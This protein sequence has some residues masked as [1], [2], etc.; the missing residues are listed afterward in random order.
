MRRRQG[1]G[2]LEERKQRDGSIRYMPRLPDKRRTPLGTFPDR[3]YAEKILDAAVY[4]LACGNLKTSNTLDAYAGTVFDQRELEGNKSVGT[5]RERWR[6]VTGHPKLGRKRWGCADWPLEA[7]KKKDVVEWRDALAKLGLSRSTRKN[8]LSTLRLV[9]AAAV[10]AG[11]LEYNPAADVHVKGKSAAKMRPLTLD[12]LS[13]L[14]WNADDEGKHLVAIAVGTCIRQGEHR[15]LLTSEVHVAARAPYIEINRSGPSTETTKSER[16]RHVPLFGFALEAMRTWKPTPNERGLH[17]ATSPAS[18]SG[19]SPERAAKYIGTP[20][21]K[22]SMVPRKRWRTWLD[23]AGI[24]RKVRWHDLRHTGATLL[25]TGALGRAW[26]LEE[27]KDLL[28]HSSLAVTER[29][30]QSLNVIAM[31]AAK[32]H[33]GNDGSSGSGGDNA[34]AERRSADHDASSTAM[35]G[36]VEMVDVVARRAPIAQRIRDTSESNRPREAREL[37][38]ERSHSNATRHAV[39]HDRAELEPPSRLE[40]ETY[41]LRTRRSNERISTTSLTSATEIRKM[42]GFVVVLDEA[43]RV[44]IAILERARDHKDVP[45]RF[46]KLAGAMLD[47]VDDVRTLALIAKAGAS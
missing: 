16:S 1:T 38:V 15:A 17:F 10:D 4:E 18:L 43:E 12:Q 44:A 33:G 35:V 41:G 46:V 5:E 45:R 24:D 25:L 31:R 23:A 6:Y 47:A 32:E 14:F 11:K 26:S 8:A 39:I 21:R 22:G 34:H 30:A 40:L 36:S 29:Y 13:A 27:L 19:W 37:L 3:A 28:G 42:R 2:T 7:I 9:F 20:R